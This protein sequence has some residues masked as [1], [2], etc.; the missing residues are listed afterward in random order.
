MNYNSYITSSGKTDKDGDPDIV[1]YNVDIISGPDSDKQLGG[2]SNILQ[3]NE[4]RSTPIINNISKYYFSIIRFNMSGPNKDLPLAVLPIKTGQTNLNLT[5]LK[6]RIDAKIKY[7][8]GV[9]VV[10]ATL[11]STKDVIYVSESLDAFTNGGIPLPQQPIE[12]VDRRGIYYWL[13]SYDHFSKLINTTIQNCFDDIQTQLNALPVPASRPIQ[14]QPAKLIYNENSKLFDFYFDARGWSDLSSCNN[15]IGSST[16]S[17]IFTMSFNSDL[18]NLLNNFDYKNVGIGGGATTLPY[19]FLI[20]NKNYKNYYAPTTPLATNLN[21]QPSTSGYFVMTQNYESTSSL[22]SPISSIVFTSGTLP[23]V[24]EL[25]GAPNIVNDNL[26]TQTTNAFQP[27]I[28]DIA[29]GMDNGASSYREFISYVPSGE[30]RMSSFMNNQQPLTQ[31]D[32]QIYWKSRLDLKLYPIAM[33]AF[34]S[35]SLKIMFKKKYL[36]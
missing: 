8:N 4:T 34:S 35:A 27:I 13:Y 31:I 3:F 21:P 33:P 15:S 10:L 16:T 14:T 32:L 29:L 26:G 1:Y 5:T 7:N 22:W 19:Q 28:T 25:T 9:S 18:Y 6:I 24:N 12:T 36:I 11:H 2:D 20:S 30:Y 23:L 17:E